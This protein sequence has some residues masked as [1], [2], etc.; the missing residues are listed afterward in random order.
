MLSKAERA[1]ISRTT[2]SEVWQPAHKRVEQGCSA[3]L[4]SFVAQEPGRRLNGIERAAK[5]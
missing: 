4:F 3:K 2:D 1:G 5:R